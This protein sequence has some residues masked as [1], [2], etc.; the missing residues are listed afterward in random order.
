MLGGARA[1]G[2]FRGTR[3]KLAGAVWGILIAMPT[4]KRIG[5]L[6]GVLVALAPRLAWAQPGS[7]LPQDRPASLP[8]PTPAAPVLDTRSVRSLHLDLLG[9]PP[10]RDEGERWIGKPF[11]ELVDE[12]VGSHG[13]WEQ[14]FEEQLYYFLLVNN[15]RPQAERVLA[16]PADLAARKLDVRAAIHL[17][18]LSP[19]FDLRNPG[20]DTFVTVVMEQLNG[21]QVQKSPRDLEIGKKLYDG[22]EGV[23]LGVAGHS[24]ADVVRIAVENKNFARHFIGRE[25]ERVVHRK[26]DAKEWAASAAEF[27]RDPAS[28]AAIV[29]RWVTSDVYQTRL[30][31]RVAQPNRLFVRALFVDL[32]DRMPTKEESEPMREALDGLSDPAPLRAILV[33][34]MLD[35]GQVPV[36]KRDAI[37]DPAAWVQKLFARLLGRAPSAPELATFVAALSE[38]DCRPQTVLCALLSSAEYQQY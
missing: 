10:L 33:R 28:Y 18:A 6:F 16:I 19:N 9:R 38:P 32:L 17:I 25:F 15:F 26:I 36:V 34:M 37:G 5:L 29:R 20:A 35:S 3:A 14:W 11:A 8:A 13:F 2:L 1:S 27:Q 30:E 24:Q 22:G 4:G 21:V 12:I 31:N 23:F 7:P